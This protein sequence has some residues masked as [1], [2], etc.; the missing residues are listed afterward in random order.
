MRKRL[1][2]STTLPLALLGLLSACGS[3]PPGPPQLQERGL[4]AFHSIDLRGVGTVDVLVGPRQ[5]VVLNAPAK[6]L[7]AVTT[8]VVNGN[9]V[10]DTEGLRGWS[11]G[12]SAGSLEL[13][14]TMPELKSLAV[15]GAGRVSL[16]GL[17]G[18]AVTMVVSGA[19]DV[20][21]GGTLDTV[22]ARLNGAGR[23]DL[24]R[25][26]A[27][28]AEVQVNG[29]GKMDVHATRR[30]EATLNGVGSIDYAGSPQELLTTLNG[31][32]RITPVAGASP[33]P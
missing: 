21:A 13:R 22:T 33:A 1:W 10:I 31:L 14:I 26:V 25:L 5:T 18:G 3:E 20:E 9:L 27:G 15:N 6:V 16:S 11:T 28:V 24:S 4:D 32:G 8:T 7:E 23:M 19:G 2:L 30:L 17:R 12:Q 29:A